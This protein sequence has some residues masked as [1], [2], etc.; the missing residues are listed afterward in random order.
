MLTDI[1]EVPI[2]VRSSSILEDGY[3]NSFSGKYESV[4]CSNIGTMDERLDA[5]ENAIKRVY[6]SALSVDALEYRKKEIYLINMNK[7]LC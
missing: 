1:G 3:D 4:F 6:A 2:I 5:L 7:W